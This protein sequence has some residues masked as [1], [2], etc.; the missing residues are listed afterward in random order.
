MKDI[1]I[2][3]AG[4]YGLEVYYEIKD[5]NT[6]AINAGKE[7]KYNILGFINDIPDALDG[8][9]LDVGI[10]GTIKDWKPS[11]DEFYALGLSKPEQKKK[12]AQM[13][14][15]RGAKFESIVSA[16]AK[17]PQD[18]VMGEGCFITSATIGCGVKLGD[19]VNINGSMIYGG[20]QIGDYSTTTGFT[21]IEDSIV[22]N[23]VFVGSKAIVTSGCRVGD[24]AQISA[25]SVV[26]SD[27]EP[28]ALMFG[29]PAQRMN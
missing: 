16:Y 12:V 20:A 23:G 8:K 14:K 10:I 11:G 21:V 13:L 17:V 2:V 24:G 18:I 6:V 22:G 3:C 27:V 4:G 7:P 1:I 25:G 26:M 9:N 5:I 28:G 19:F 15:A 29:M